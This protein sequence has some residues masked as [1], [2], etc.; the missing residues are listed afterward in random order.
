MA[1]QYSPT[2]PK[3]LSYPGEG[4]CGWRNKAGSWEQKTS[5]IRSGATGTC[6]TLAAAARVKKQDK[7]KVLALPVQDGE[8]G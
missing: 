3:P 8:A 7:T 6:Q 2:Q 4:M 5:I 1:A